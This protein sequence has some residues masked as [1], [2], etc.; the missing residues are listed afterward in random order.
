MKLLPFLKDKCLL[1]LLHLSC[2]GLLSVFLRL[3]GY[4]STGILLILIFWL[5]ILLAWLAV[6]FHQRRRYFSE[7]QKLLEHLDQR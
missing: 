3:T 5:L 1:L 7:I 6:T 2:M 4:S